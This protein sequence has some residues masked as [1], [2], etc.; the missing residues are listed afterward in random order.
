MEGRATQHFAEHSYSSGLHMPHT[1]KHTI[2]RARTVRSACTDRGR[3]SD[4]VLSSMRPREA[5][6]EQLSFADLGSALAVHTASVSL[7][8]TPPSATM[9]AARPACSHTCSKN[10]RSGP[11]MYLA[12]L[13]RSWA[14]AH[15]TVHS[16]PAMA[17][18]RAVSSSTH[19]PPLHC[20][21][22]QPSRALHRPVTSV[23]T[24]VRCTHDQPSDL[25]H[26]SPLATNSSAVV[27]A[28]KRS[29]TLGALPPDTY[30]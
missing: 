18:C 13:T 27:T 19:S 12:P 28:L 14:Q 26:T 1:K 3:Q 25:P 11:T 15:T 8:S 24:V 30:E 2:V 29:L 6:R 10:E 16:R 4:A 22:H 5:P 7:H 20:P 21:I 17:D 23:G 9:M